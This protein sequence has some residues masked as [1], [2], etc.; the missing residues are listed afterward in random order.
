MTPKIWGLMLLLVW[1]ALLL[2][3]PLLRF[4]PLG[5]DEGAARA[6]LL[7][8]SIADQV[9]SPVVVLGVPDLRALLFIPLALYWS[10]SVIAAKV[11]TALLT[12]AAAMLVFS[13]AWRR[14]GNETA[15]IATGLLLI[16][17]LTLTQ[18]DGVGTGPYLLLALGFGIW[19]ED[20][21][22]RSTRPTGSWFYLRLLTVAYA[23][24][25]HPAGLAYGLALLWR[26]FRHPSG[27][28]KQRQ[29]NLIGIGVALVFVALLQA[30]WTQLA[31]FGN[32]LAALGA[33]FSST[34]LFE[35][36]TWAEGLAP[37]A[38]AVVLLWLERD[39]LLAE[40][41][42]TLFLLAMLLGLFAADS[43]WAYVVMAFVL[44]FGTA[45]LIALNERLTGAGFFGQRGLVMIALVV[46]ATVFMRADRSYW[47]A[48]RQELLAPQDELIREVAATAERGGK[49]TRI[50]SQW[51]AKT[52]IACRCDALPLPPYTEDA[53]ALMRMLGNASHLVFDPRDTRNT[54]LSRAISQ[55]SG[56]MATTWLGEGGVIV[57]IVKTESVQPS[58]PAPAATPNVP[59]KS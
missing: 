2:A 51:P 50:V 52:M 54:Y 39:K 56:K 24:T 28:A 5:I 25:L 15:L 22:E 3:L 27:T 11:Y 31:W 38:V 58:G 45:R 47:E 8:W 7:D 46:V 53:D 26:W 42:G 29:Q 49:S 6:L 35:S 55:Q 18:I 23:A 20:A 32:P 9:A 19:M 30:G 21:Y 16:A 41:A 48:L 37:A 59:P 34:R 57:E 33:I 40:L 10:G 14:F 12:F 36:P 43:A 44:Y 17:P 13:W 1:G 4:A